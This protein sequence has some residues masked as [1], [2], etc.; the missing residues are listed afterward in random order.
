MFKR[1]KKYK[2][3]V[4]VG[5]FAECY[6]GTCTKRRYVNY[7]KYLWYKLNGYSARKEEVQKKCLNE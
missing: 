4:L 3:Y 7:F 2:Y 5:N 6:F 1:V